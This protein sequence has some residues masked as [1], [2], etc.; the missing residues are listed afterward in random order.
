VWGSAQARGLRSGLGCGGASRPL[1]TPDLTSSDL[2]VA[3][4]DSA[5]RSIALLFDEPAGVIA[6]RTAGV[7]EFRAT[8]AWQSPED[9]PPGPLLRDLQSYARCSITENEGPETSTRCLAGEIRA[10][11]QAELASALKSVLSTVTEVA[12]I[13]EA[14]LEVAAVR[15]VPPGVPSARALEELARDIWA[16]G[17]RVRFESSWTPGLGADVC[18]GVGDDGDLQEFLRSHPAWSIA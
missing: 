14:M 12:A 13:K 16:A 2:L 3:R 1:R 11:K 6:T 17:F 5:R 15:T 8:L 18:V 10:L 4:K 9:A 7:V